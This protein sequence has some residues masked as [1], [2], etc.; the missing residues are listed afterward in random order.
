[1][2]YQHAAK[3]RR[4]D[5]RRGRA[6]DA[7][8]DIRSCSRAGIRPTPADGRKAS[9]GQCVK[10]T[11]RGAISGAIAESK[12]TRAPWRMPARRLRRRA[13]RDFPSLGSVSTAFI[14]LGL[15]A[16]PR[17]QAA[18]GGD[19]RYTFRRAADALHGRQRPFPAIPRWRPRC[20]AWV[21]AR[22]C[23]SSSA[24]RVTGRLRSPGVGVSHR[25]P[26]LYPADARSERRALE[27]DFLA[28]KS[29]SI[30][31]DCR[32]RV[33]TLTRDID[34][35]GCSGWMRTRLG[36]TNGRT[37]RSILVL[38]PWSPVAVTHLS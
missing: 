20:S 12:P 15:I 13:T 28:T 2:R 16:Q 34:R 27:G 19:V 24:P 14:R 18:P 32:H 26:A 35:S 29:D 30:G 1:M 5:R 31:R 25:R 3:G 37:A 21:R 11:A 4:P 10:V 6:R 36:G 17:G 7:A 8:A 22:C 38:V 33:Q 9:V 23:L